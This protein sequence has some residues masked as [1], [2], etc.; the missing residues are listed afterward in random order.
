MIFSILFNLKFC[1]KWHRSSIDGRSYYDLTKRKTTFKS[2]FNSYSFL[3]ENIRLFIEDWK[4]NPIVSWADLSK[5]YP[6][7]TLTLLGAGLS[8]AQAF[9]VY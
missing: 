5:N 4:Y 7:G 8:I 1:D 9:Q 3:Y 2:V 6:W